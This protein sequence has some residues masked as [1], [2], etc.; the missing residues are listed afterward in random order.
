[1]VTSTGKK[2]VELKDM[3][4]GKNADS[5]LALKVYPTALTCRDLSLH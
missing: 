5:L 2:L 1:M 3:V 4:P